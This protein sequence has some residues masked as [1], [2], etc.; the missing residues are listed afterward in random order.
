MS[1]ATL[2]RVAREQP[3]TLAQLSALPGMGEWFLRRHGR[4]AL[5]AIERGHARPQ[6]RLP[7]PPRGTPP[8]P[9]NASRERYARLK[10]WRKTRAAEREVEPD[11]IVSNDA[12]I[13]IARQNPKTVEALGLVDAL[14]TWKAH[15][16]GA[17][18]LD[19]LS[20]RK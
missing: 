20:A 8:L 17:E 13:E 2:V 7:K 11:V 10:E 18:L 4:E 14:G 19:I 12:L 15:E 3:Q 6:M 5:Q 1:N 16:Y 9:D